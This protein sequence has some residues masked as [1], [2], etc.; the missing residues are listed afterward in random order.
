M[1]TLRAQAEEVVILATAQR[2][3]ASEGLR[4]MN[5]SHEMLRQAP[6][7]RQRE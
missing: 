6:K 1:H 4:E 5:R 7:K 2:V 3:E